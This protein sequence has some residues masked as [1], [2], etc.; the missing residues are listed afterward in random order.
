MVKNSQIE[1]IRNF[2]I[3]FIETNFSIKINMN[4]LLMTLKNR[5]ILAYFCP[6]GNTKLEKEFQMKSDM[7]FPILTSL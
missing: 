5:V 2:V 6:S 7:T 1:Y 4:I 3:T